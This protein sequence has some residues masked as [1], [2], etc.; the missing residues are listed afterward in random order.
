M[1]IKGSETGGSHAQKHQF[2]H[3]GHRLGLGGDFLCEVQSIHGSMECTTVLDN[4]IVGPIPVSWGVGR[5]VS[6]PRAYPVPR[7]AI[8]EPLA[9]P[10]PPNPLATWQ[11]GSRAIRG[12]TFSADSAHIPHREAE[13]TAF[14]SCCGSAEHSGVPFNKRVGRLLEGLRLARALWSGQ[15]VNWDGRWKFEKAV[16]G[17]TPCRAGGPPIW[18]GG[19][20]PASLERAGRYFDGGLPISPDAQTWGK[21]WKQVQEI[22]RAAGATPMH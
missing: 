8:K 5:S 2:C 16:L 22:A 7:P 20:L 12:G 15:P 17:P 4:R 6:I 1:G 10:L 9:P 13:P 11:S 18:I 19:S 14:R 3:C 21:Q